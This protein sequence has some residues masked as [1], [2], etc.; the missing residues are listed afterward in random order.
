MIDFY[1]T[2][3]HHELDR[4]LETRSV[5]KTPIIFDDGSSW[6]VEGDRI[7]GFHLVPVKEKN[8]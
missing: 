1:K 3:L 5:D 4:Y 8:V 2:I 7:K 6:V